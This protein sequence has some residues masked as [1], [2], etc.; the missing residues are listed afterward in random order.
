MQGRNMTLRLS[1]ELAE[2]L[3]AVAEA[4]GVPVSEAARMAIAEHIERRRND[5]AF[6]ARLKTSI[7]RNQRILERLAK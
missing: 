3:E 6:Q 7:E 5:K 4:D 2:A 1:R